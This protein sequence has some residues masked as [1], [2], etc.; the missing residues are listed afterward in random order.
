[1]SCLLFQPS[2]LFEGANISEDTLIVGLWSDVSL[3]RCK[4]AEW[5]VMLD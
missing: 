4:P 1:M 5:D 2:V 3:I